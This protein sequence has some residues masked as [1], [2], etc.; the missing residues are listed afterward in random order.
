VAEK[1]QTAVGGAKRRWTKR[2]STHLA[3]A[4]GKN[5]KLLDSEEKKKEFLFLPPLSILPSVKRNE[6][7]TFSFVSCL[8]APLSGSPAA[9]VASVPFAPRVKW[10]H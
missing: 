6:D 4:S 9:F 3:A 5:K 1:V 2:L 8:S 10:L 7:E